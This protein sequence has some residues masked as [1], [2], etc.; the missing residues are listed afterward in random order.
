MRQDHPR[1]GERNADRGAWAQM[2]FSRYKGSNAWAPCAPVPA[3]RT[4]TLPSLSSMPASV[5]TLWKDGKC[6][7]HE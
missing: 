5:K 7:W 3:L 2:Q 1:S 6:L 4:L